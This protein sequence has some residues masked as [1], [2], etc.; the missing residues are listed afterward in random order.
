MTV[1]RSKKAKSRR[2]SKRI[3]RSLGQLGGGVGGTITIGQY[4]NQETFLKSFLSGT[5]TLFQ[6]LDAA[7]PTS[8]TYDLI[9][10]P[11][12][13]A[14]TNY[15]AWTDKSGNGRNMNYN[16]GTPK[17]TPNLS[18]TLGVG[19]AD[20]SPPFGKPAFDFTASD[21]ARLTSAAYPK[22][23]NCTVFVMGL[24]PAP[25]VYT[26]SSA[27]TCTTTS[28]GNGTIWGHYGEPAAQHDAWCLHLR[29]NSTTYQ[30]SVRTSANDYYPTRGNYGTS[31]GTVSPSITANASGNLLPTNFG[32]CSAVTTSRG[33]NLDPFTNKPIPLVPFIFVASVGNP[34]LGLTAA[35]MTTYLW[36][37]NLSNT[38]NSSSPIAPSASPPVGPQVV[39]YTGAISTSSYPLTGNSNSGGIFMGSSDSGSEYA[40]NYMCESIYYQNTSFTDNDVQA[41]AGYLAWKWG[42]EKCLTG[43]FAAGSPY[44]TPTAS[45]ALASSRQ[46]SSAVASAAQAAAAQASSSLASAQQAKAGQVSAAEASSRQAS[47]AVVSAAQ[48]SSAV[49]SSARASTAQASSAV[50]SSAQASMATVLQASTAVASAAQA[51]AAQAS[52]SLTSAA[53]A[54]AAEPSAAQASVA[55]ASSAVVSSA[56]ASSAQASSAVASAA[57]ASMA[58]VLQASTAI[59]SA[60][61]ASS[62]QASS[63]LTSAAQ[64]SSAYPSAA[65]A[66]TAQASAAQA[67]RS[68][69]SAAQAS[70]AFIP[71]KPI[72]LSTCPTGYTGQS[73][74]T[75]TGYPA[76]STPAIGD[77]SAFP[78]SYYRSDYGTCHSDTLGYRGQ[79]KYSCASGTQSANACYKCP[80]GDYV[81]DKILGTCY[82][83]KPLECPSGYYMINGVC[84]TQAA[85]APIAS[86]AQASTAQASTAQVSAAQ[87]SAA[88]ASSAQ[89][90]AAQLSSARDSAAQAALS[91]ASSARTSSA[92]ASAAQ[93]SSAQASAAQLSSARDSAA[94][95]AA[96]IAS[97][98][99]AYMEQNSAAIAS[100]QQASAAQVSSARESSAQAAL[101]QASAAKVSGNQ[102]SAAQA[103]YAQTSS[104]QDS[105]AQ[106]SS[107]QTSSAQASS[108]VASAAVAAASIAS[109]AA[110]YMEQNSAAIASSQ[111][112]SAAQASSAQASSAQAALAQAS[113]AKVSGQQASAAAASSAQGSA[114]QGSAAQASS[115]QASSAQASSAQASSAQAALAQASAAMASAGQASAAIA[116]TAQANKA[117]GIDPTNG[118]YIFPS[119]ELDQTIEINDY[120]CQYIRIRP[121]MAQGDGFIHFSQI[122]IYD[123]GGTL[124]S[125]SALIFANSTLSTVKKPQI[126]LDGT[127]TPRT[128]PNIWHSASN[129]RN[130]EYVEIN[131]MVPQTVSSIRIIG[132]ADCPPNYVNCKQRM[133]FLRVELNSSTTADAMTYYNTQAAAIAAAAAQASAAKV[134]AAQAALIMQRNAE[135][136]SMAT[137]SSAKAS[138][139]QA[140]AAEASSAVASGQQA[141][142]AVASN[143][144]QLSAQASAA[145]ASAAKASAAFVMSVE[146][147]KA[148]AAQAAAAQASSSLASAAVASSSLASSAMASTA[149]QLSAQAS[150]AQ[151]SSAMASV[152]QGIIAL[153]LD[154]PNGKYILSAMKNDQSISAR[155]SAR[156]IRVRPAL[157][158]GDGYIQICQ[159]AVMNLLGK[160]LALNAPVYASSSQDQ[161]PSCVVDGVLK[162]R[163]L[164]WQNATPNVDD[165]I[166]IDLGDKRD[167]A[168]IRIIGPP[169]S[170]PRMVQAR[171][172][173][174]LTTTKDVLDFYAEAKVAQQASAAKA[175]MLT[176]SAAE[177]SSAGASAAQASTA[178][179]LLDSSAT[180]S[181]AQASAAAA[182]SAQLFLSQ[183][184]LLTGNDPKRGKFV[185]PTNDADQTIS[186]NEYEGRYI[187][188]RPSVLNGDGWLNISQVIVNDVTLSNIAAGKLVYATSNYPQ[189]E[190]PTIVVDDSR[191][192]R[193]FPNLWQAGT[194]ARDKEFLEIDLGDMNF[195]S[196]IQILGRGNCRKAQYCIDRMMG[197]RIEINKHTNPNVLNAYASG[198]LAKIPID[199]DNNPPAGRFII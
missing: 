40:I 80:V 158:Q 151:A 105:S 89:D 51:S 61:Q 15:M 161:G 79:P 122:M 133:F 93:A 199:P 81:Y 120:S 193:D 88:Q 182:S 50:A 116:S 169:T 113:A 142:A 118:R 10:Q 76:T 60:A 38:V 29:R 8:T 149:Q 96:S 115:A 147:Q 102:A 185:L 36:T 179:A 66:S 188:I 9:S 164:S 63:S 128:I 198:A 14:A 117:M 177:A 186:T 87:A 189:T 159:I 190:N 97:A 137:V 104:A 155:K 127:T 4:T 107:A 141:S 140:A 174:N 178:Q 165:F 70:A 175:S 58:S 5:A 191:A 53:Q 103:S 35:D 71:I 134:S 131:L 85:S 110:A 181:T 192:V 162:A 7:N 41:I 176:A 19:Q 125:P 194:N 183:Q 167:I 146:G 82:Y 62:A 44:M 111:Q 108:A 31:V 132:R 163:T 145:A 3:P 106:A 77:C 47:S 136:L 180:A 37:T 39:K 184:N 78:G 112:A 26:A 74:T 69:A 148:S 196:S 11:G 32:T 16:R 95:A 153:G 86:A 42:M 20:S 28:Y 138:A 100:S 139:M 73:T 55:Q 52:R 45:A 121:S 46:A 168:L 84:Y 152:A 59:V 30:I 98:A 17:F 170:E 67:S 64:A 24:M 21:G 43:T 144:Q 135:E 150:A 99:A 109:A 56:R 172:E 90:S 6:W 72:I 124:I 173:A 101:S 27:T 83:N 114:A 195:I 18:T 23:S 12:S 143:A 34:G 166:E 75:C 2:K 22:A 25:L 57:Q 171:V 68:A 1:S 123:I 65:Q 33:V 119:S 91:Q 94:V 126:L 129:N 156:Y 13:V 187:R 160:N 92:Q 157:Y 130:T 49:V 154:P 48:A 54:S 197:L